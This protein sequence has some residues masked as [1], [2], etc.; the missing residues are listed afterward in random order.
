MKL[1]IISQDS[2][3]ISFS[4]GEG[5]VGMLYNYTDHEDY[6][7]T[8]SGNFSQNYALNQPITSDFFSINLTKSIATDLPVGT[9]FYFQYMPFQSAVGIYRNVGIS[10]VSEGASII[11]LSM[12]GA[13]KK[14]LVE[15]LNTSVKILEQ[16]KI[17]QKTLYARKTKEYI[18]D[19]FEREARRLDTIAKE[20]GDFK[21][22][23]KIYNLSNEGR[24]IFNQTLTWEAEIKKIDDGLAYLQRLEIYL[25]NNDTYGTKVPIPAVLRIEDSKIPAAISELITKSSVRQSLR[26]TVKDTHPQMQRLNREIEIQKNN[27]FENISDLRKNL[28]IENRTL[29]NR[30]AGY[31]EK[32]LRLP[33][34]EQ[35]LINYQRNYSFSEANYSYLKQKS[36][37]AGTAIAANVSD[38]RVIDSAMDLGQGPIYPKPSF[39]YL[40]GIML[41]IVLPLFY[42]IIRE[43]LDN[44]ITMV[45]QI[46]NKYE[47]PILGIVGRNAGMNNLAVFE[48]P[49]SSVA[50]SFRALRSN[51]RFLL[52]GSECY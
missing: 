33:K 25:R 10:F 50:E 18:E 49:K 15:Y 16:D 38:V 30:L 11:Q 29:K 13:N 24:A 51:I 46:E 5:E 35:E 21:E 7:V 26:K 27:I 52:K 22:K 36:F 3:N 42:V 32:L 37:E 8:H 23:N 47:I 4:A 44:K 34:K 28:K 1:S 45:E 39:N 9:H 40:V 14:R 48:R 12:E 43:L 41:G 31:K 6:P 17:A 19:L 2:V 20:L